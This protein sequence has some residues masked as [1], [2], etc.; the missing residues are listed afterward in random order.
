MQG[1][2][3]SLQSEAAALRMERNAQQDRLSEQAS[4]LD[5]ASTRAKEAETALLAAQ[6]ASG[7]HEA[8]LQRCRAFSPEALCLHSCVLSEACRR[9]AFAI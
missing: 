9:L 6:Q 5:K 2:C 3:E 7:S 8:V 1:Q 4:A